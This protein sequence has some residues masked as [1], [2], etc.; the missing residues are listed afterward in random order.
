MFSASS[1]SG[2]WHAFYSGTL[3]GCS[4]T[5]TGFC[6]AFVGHPE[7]GSNT[8]LLVSYFKPDSQ[9]NANVGHVDLA[10]VPLPPPSAASPEP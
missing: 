5:P 10:L 3:P 8:S 6:Y 4:T 9:D 2:P 1:P 7:L